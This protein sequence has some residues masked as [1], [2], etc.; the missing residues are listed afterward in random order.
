[1]SNF[2]H[3]FISQAAMLQKVLPFMAN[4][5]HYGKF[6]HVWARTATETESIHTYTSQGKETTR[7]AQPGDFIVKNRTTA[8]EEY[9]VEADKFHQRYQWLRNIAEGLDEYQPKGTVLALEC[10]AELQKQLALGC[11]FEFEAAWGENQTVYT[12]DF[13]VCPPDKSEVYK[14]S[15]VEFAQTYRPLP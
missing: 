5:T 15:P 9:V 1:M 14:I 6:Q 13:L 7:M 12:G 4:A 11:P 2:P 10:D 8:A 3:I